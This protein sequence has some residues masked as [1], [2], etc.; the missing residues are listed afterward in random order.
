GATF[1]IPDF[2]GSIW[3]FEDESKRADHGL[4]TGLP[5]TIKLP[6]LNSRA[7]MCLACFNSMRRA[8]SGVF[9]INL[10][11]ICTSASEVICRVLSVLNRLR[12][13]SGA[14]PSTSGKNF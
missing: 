3:K 10:N 14:R 12:V 13:P 4:L 8:R 5:V 2:D 6:S 7:D 1:Q 11:R 9:C